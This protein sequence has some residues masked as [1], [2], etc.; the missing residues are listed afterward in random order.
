MI[1]NK[2]A[3]LVAELISSLHRVR[4]RW[5]ISEMAPLTQVYNFFF[6]VYVF[7]TTS[8][9]VAAATDCPT[10]Y[11]RSMPK[12]HL[13]S[14]QQKPVVIGHRGNPT[15]FQ[16]NTL[17]GFTSLLEIGADGFELDIYLTKDEQLAVYHDDTTVV[18]IN[19]VI[20]GN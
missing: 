10:G 20:F 14:R 18:C 9:P 2:Q 5:W 11:V 8:S 17:E 6:L 19:L 3:D 7:Q 15:V 13:F 16:E 1:H 12:D 4:V